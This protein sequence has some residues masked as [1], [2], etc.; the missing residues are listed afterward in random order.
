MCCCE[1]E[2]GAKRDN[3]GRA[4]VD[5]SSRS[6]LKIVEDATEAHGAKI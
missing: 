4:F 1:Q 5:I 2:E 6:D 3:E